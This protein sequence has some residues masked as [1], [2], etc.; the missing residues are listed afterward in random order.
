MFQVETM[1][2]SPLFISG[3]EVS[4][5]FENLDDLISVIQDGFAHF[6]KGENGGVI[7]PVRSVVL[8]PKHNT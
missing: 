1:D 6:S 2:S 3:S 5:A 7:Q 8:V 4:K